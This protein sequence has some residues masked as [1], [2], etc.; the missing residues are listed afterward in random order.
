VAVLVSS[1]VDSDGVVEEGTSE[2]AAAVSV[3]TVLE[4]SPEIAVLALA[5]PV[6]ATREL[7][8]VA[9]APYIDVAKSVMV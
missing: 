9:E 2:L 7:L 8:L 5:P 3:G 4:T 1:A 6:G